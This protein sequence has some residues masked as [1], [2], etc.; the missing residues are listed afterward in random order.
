MKLCVI[1]PC[2][3]DTRATR[4]EHYRIDAQGTAIE[5]G[6]CTTCFGSIC[7]LQL[8][9]D[10]RGMNFLSAGNSYTKPMCWV[11]NVIGRRNMRCFKHHGIG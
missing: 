6:Q 1:L 8:S 4:F 3:S 10:K 9:P 7:L 2:F 5:Y 11:E